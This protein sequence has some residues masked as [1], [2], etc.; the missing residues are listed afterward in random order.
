MENITGRIGLIRKAKGYEHEIVLGES[1][2]NIMLKRYGLSLEILDGNFSSIP[3]DGPLILV[4]NHPFGILDGLILGYILSKSRQDFKIL[5]NQV[6]CKSD[7][8]NDIILP[9]SFDETKEASKMNIATRLSALNFL[10]NGGAI[11]VFPGG[12]VSTAQNP[13]GVPMDPGWGSFTA[14]MIT[15]SDAQ[16]V[17]IF[18]EGHNSRLFQMASHIHYNLRMGLLLSLIHI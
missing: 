5:A 10:D 11:G 16:V 18:F 6:F 14:K 3:K 9:I 12:T 7:D 4:A 13:F 1:F 2:W 17:P 8:L 15:R